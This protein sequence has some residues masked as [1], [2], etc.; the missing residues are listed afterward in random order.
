M[1]KYLTITFLCLQTFIYAQHHS[2]HADGTSR[3]Y[4][5]L[6]SL[7]DTFNLAE[8]FSHG[9]VNGHL[10]NFFMSTIN[11]GPAK[12]YYTNASGMSLHYES[13]PF[14]GFLFEVKGIFTFQTFGMDI[15]E[16]DEKTGEPAKWESE[17]YDVL[18]R[19]NKHD[20]DRLEE[21]FIEYRVK[22]NVF[23]YGR[24]SIDETPLL[25]ERDDRM[26]AFAFKGFYG[27]WGIHK[28]F[29]MKNIFINGASPRSMVEWFP[30]NEVIGLNY[31]GYA[32][33]G[34]LGDYHHH[35][36]PDFL[37]ANEILFKQDGLSIKLWNFVLD[38][39]FHLNWFQSEWMEKSWEIG[40]I[41]MHQH[42]LNHQSKLEVTHQKLEANT[43]T[44]ANSYLLGKNIGNLLIAGAF[45]HI[46][47][48][49]RFIFPR[50]LGRER[51]YTS[52]LRSWA[53]GLGNA[54]IS[55]ISAIYSPKKKKE[56]K[57]DASV[58]F[59]NAPGAENYKYN[60]YGVRDYLQYSLDVDY[61]FL[62]K[63][64]GLETQLIY[65]YRQDIDDGQLTAKESFNNTNFHQFNF[66]VNVNF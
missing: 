27:D 54:N 43:N 25:N 12:D 37:I 52:T 55:K 56:V 7:K 4:K 6:F 31:N 17:L 62:G 29:R 49:G 2:N 24:I 16:E 35:L 34:E 8:H 20:L 28:G 23:K 57:L 63:L 3:H 44:F 30:L 41:A 59:T 39:T 61:N 42:P 15:N 21:L 32:I 19:E 51:F 10:R 33:N 22:N 1:R 38:Q 40:F 26:K 9:H 53:E 11:E 50:E 36:K 65:I 48:D 66:V 5:G 58:Q 46:Y 14:Y 64:K 45:T 18:N 60:K 47:G 13:L